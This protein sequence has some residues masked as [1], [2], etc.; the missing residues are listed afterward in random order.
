MTRIALADSYLIAGYSHQQLLSHEKSVRA[1]LL[2]D[3]TNLMLVILNVL[4]SMYIKLL[5]QRQV[6]VSAS[7]VGILLDIR[8]E[9]KQVMHI[10][11]GWM[12]CDGVISS[13]GNLSLICDL[14]CSIE[15][16]SLCD[17]DEDSRMNPNLNSQELVD[18]NE[19]ITR[20]YDGSSFIVLS[21]FITIALL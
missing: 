13:D 11:I 5:Y 15:S 4:M 17:D 3:C 14:I 20:R 9:V 21:S 2:G 18:I 16:S 19:S 12:Y 8:M 10:I 7:L 6:V 1:Q